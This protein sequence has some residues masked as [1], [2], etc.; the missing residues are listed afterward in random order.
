MKLNH[1]FHFSGEVQNQQACVGLFSCQKRDWVFET[2]IFFFLGIRFVCWCITGESPIRIK[3]EIS[4]ASISREFFEQK[5]HTWVP[6]VAVLNTNTMCHHQSRPTSQGT[7]KLFGDWTH[8]G[9]KACCD[10]ITCCSLLA[11]PFYT[12]LPNNEMWKLSIS[13]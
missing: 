6:F 1:E 11:P 2:S 9:P 4:K 5:W 10:A 3:H 8:F 13:G 7:R 12:L